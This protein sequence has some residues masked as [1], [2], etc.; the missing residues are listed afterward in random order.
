MK[1]ELPMVLIGHANYPRVTPIA[2]P[3]RYQRSGSLIFSARKIGYRGLVVSDDLEMGGVLT[4]API[5]QAAIEHIRAGGD[6]C[7]ICQSKTTSRVPTKRWSQEV[8]R[9][10]RFALTRSG[11]VERVLAFKKKS[12]ELKRFALRARPIEKVEKLSRQAMGI[13]RAGAD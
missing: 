13:Q 2:C 5:E 12:I 1:R 6:L 4:A 8:E 9:D 3:L 11:I 10:R 7:L